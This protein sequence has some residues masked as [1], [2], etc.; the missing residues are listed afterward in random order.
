MWRWKT[1][2]LYVKRIPDERVLRVVPRI[3]SENVGGCIYGTQT[4]GYSTFSGVKVSISGGKKYTLN[5]QFFRPDPMTPSPGGQAPSSVRVFQKLQRQT[6][7][8]S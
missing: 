4:R 6:K 5:I 8:D 2:R 1:Q 7:N 3:I